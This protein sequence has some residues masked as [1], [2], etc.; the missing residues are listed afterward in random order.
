MLIN[1]TPFYVGSS[2]VVSKLYGNWT[3]QKF[4]VVDSTT[5]ELW[6]IRNDNSNGAQGYPTV[7]TDPLVGD[8]SISFTDS[9][10][11]TSGEW[12]GL[13]GMTIADVAG[14][15]ILPP[16]RKWFIETCDY[17]GG[18][19]FRKGYGGYTYTSPGARSIPRVY[20]ISRTGSTIS[21]SI[22]AWTGTNFT[23]AGD[24]RLGLYFGLWTHISPGITAMH[25]L[26]SWT[27]YSLQ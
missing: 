9:T 23:Y 14:A 25:T 19:L 1:T 3:D 24:V 22:N 2:P 27:G 12:H 26:H 5:V 4:N 20:T 10:P 7:Q 13:V 8:F 21:T 6:N 11:F 18:Y 15:E 16:T 17:G